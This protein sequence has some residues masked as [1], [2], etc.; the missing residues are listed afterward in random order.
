MSTDG[1]GHDLGKMNAQALTAEI[2]RIEK[3][4]TIKT[5]QWTPPMTAEQRSKAVE[6]T[7]AAMGLRHQMATGH[8]AKELNRTLEPHQMAAMSLARSIANY[9]APGTPNPFQNEQLRRAY[10]SEQAF[11]ANVRAQ[12]AKAKPTN[13][14]DVL[15]QAKALP[16]MYSIKPQQMAGA[17]APQ[18][19][20]KAKRGMSR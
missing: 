16:P 4:I 9:D 1:I 19:K 6:L 18:Q 14:A 3:L 17:A 11:A 20:P 10:V 5:N 7:E 12:D 13:S 15:S 8:L 2:G